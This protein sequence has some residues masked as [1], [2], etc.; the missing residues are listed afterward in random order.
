MKNI[1]F[2]ISLFLTFSVKAVETTGKIIEVTPTKWDVFLIKV[3]NK[4]T[5]ISCDSNLG[6]A[7]PTN[8]S[9]GKAAIAT[10]IAAKTTGNTVQV[11]GDDTCSYWSNTEDLAYF[12]VQ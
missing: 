4:N 3:T 11:Y 1:F 2:L 7:I 6:Y 12:T 10:A 8:T 5:S 9:W